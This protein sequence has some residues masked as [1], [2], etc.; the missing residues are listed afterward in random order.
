LFARQFVQ[1][2]LP[3]GSIINCV[4]RWL[5]WRKNRQQFLVLVSGPADADPSDPAEDVFQQ[6]LLSALHRKASRGDGIGRL[7]SMDERIEGEE[8]ES[9]QGIV[10]HE[11]NPQEA[12]LAEQANKASQKPT[13]Q[14]SASPTLGS[15]SSRG[16][17]QRR[18]DGRVIV[19]ADDQGSY[20][21]TTVGQ[22][23]QDDVEYCDRTT[24]RRKSGRS[25]ADF[26]DHS[27]SAVDDAAFSH[28]TQVFALPKAG[29][30]APS[31]ASSNITGEDGMLGEYKRDRSRYDQYANA[32]ADSEEGAASH[33]HEGYDSDEGIEDTLN[34][35]S[36]GFAV[37][38]A[39][40]GHGSTTTMTVNGL[41][42]KTMPRP[43]QVYTTLT[44]KPRVVP[45]VQSL[46]KN[47]AAAE[48][49]QRKDGTMRSLHTASTH[50]VPEAGLSN[51]VAR[52]P[53]LRF[54]EVS[55]GRV[56][57]LSFQLTN[58]GNEVG[59]FRIAKPRHPDLDV[60][61]RQVPLAAGMSTQV[62][63]EF[64]ARGFGDVSE[65][66]KVITPTHILHIPVF[67]SVVDDAT[68]KLRPHVRVV[69]NAVPGA[70]LSKVQVRKPGVDS[71]PVSGRHAVKAMQVEAADEQ[72]Q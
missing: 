11:T 44:G 17:K 55:E 26:S 45:P 38:K 12:A 31:S 54:G 53:E 56:Y 71:W 64:G 49:N 25:S 10:V 30:S 21:K 72:E 60:I 32:A 24:G 33:E 62:D 69:E 20:W 4:D 68:V 43:P 41:N 19:N 70:V 66:L 37:Q 23:V 8:F 28:Q 16:G 51:I 36:S 46:K 52:P 15:L 63:V 13:K 58:V 40:H 50:V 27:S 7:N 42:R 57:R 3:H 67:S 29:Q 47:V 14:R 34:G 39:S 5:K 22:N 6:R 2:Q 9:T 1:L 35:T 59:R 48:P 18:R 65:D 61:Y